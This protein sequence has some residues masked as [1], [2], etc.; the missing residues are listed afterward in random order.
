MR[1]I[2]IEIKCDLVETYSK[3][4]SWLFQLLAMYLWLIIF[5]KP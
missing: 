4:E 5:S 2:E 3:L 1:G